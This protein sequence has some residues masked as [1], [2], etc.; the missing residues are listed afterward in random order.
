MRCLRVGR[1]RLR[2]SLGAVVGEAIASIPLRWRSCEERGRCHAFRFGSS[3]GSARAA[4]RLAPVG[5]VPPPRGRHARRPTAEA[6][7]GL[8]RAHDGRVRGARRSREI[9]T[10][11][12]PRPTARQPRRTPRRRRASAW[13]A[14]PHRPRSRARRTL[15]RPAS[16]Q[17]AIVT[18]STVVRSL[19]RWRPGWPLGRHAPRP[20][21]EVGA[22]AA[23][24]TPGPPDAVPR[25]RSEPLH[26]R[27]RR[28]S[29]RRKR[30]RRRSPPGAQVD[31][32]A[33]RQP[34]RVVQ[35][36]PWATPP[37][38]G[39]HARPPAAE[40]GAVRR[41]SRYDRRPRPRDAA[42]R[43]RSEPPTCP[44]GGVPGPA[45]LCGVAG[46][47]RGRHTSTVAFA[48]RSGFSRAISR[49]AAALP[50]A[51]VAV[52]PRPLAAPSLLVLGEAQP[53]PAPRGRAPRRHA[54]PPSAESANHGASCSNTGRCVFDAREHAPSRRAEDVARE[55][56]AHADVL[57]VPGPGF[58]SDW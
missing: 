43:A 7:R 36:A 48:R 39:R 50:E 20:A 44:L 21:A 14:R 49:K 57:C 38:L 3:A 17:A 18:T 40:G 6:A 55:R 26:R 27:I 31:V 29:R 54:V 42:R 8:R 15:S 4:G 12:M 25:T 5:H 16:R 34:A 35:R 19:R 37:P 53:R 22:L 47:P 24:T 1:A 41:T 9:R 28:L 33:S 32:F 23:R 10:A 30:V 58:V 46:F 13:P 56:A 45:H 11:V 52:A 51:A 2:Y